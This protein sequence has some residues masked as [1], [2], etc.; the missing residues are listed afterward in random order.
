M[1]FDQIIRSILLTFHYFFLVFTVLIVGSYILLAFL[2][3]KETKNY[4]KKNS[5]V[6][7][8]DLITSSIAPSISVIAPAYNESLNIVENVR[9]L[10][11]THY[12]NYE[13]IIVN[14]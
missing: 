7:H 2:S 14:D 10:L 9:S 5:F 11:S 12:V 13:V 4:L 6:N 3:S 8:K 1:E